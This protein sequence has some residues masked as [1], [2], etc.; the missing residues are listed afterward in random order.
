MIGALLYLQFII[1]IKLFFIAA[2]TVHI[3]KQFVLYSTGPEV[4]T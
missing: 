3:S 2:L 1:V 4:N